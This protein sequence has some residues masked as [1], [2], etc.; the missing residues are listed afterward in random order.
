M[1]C[2]EYFFEGRRI[3]FTIFPSKFGV[4]K[5]RKR[6]HL[7]L[8]LCCTTMLPRLLALWLAACCGITLVSCEIINFSKHVLY[9]GMRS[10]N[11]SFSLRFALVFSLFPLYTLIFILLFYYF[12]LLVFSCLNI[13]HC[14][15]RHITIHIGIHTHV[16]SLTLTQSLL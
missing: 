13:F 3:Q 1:V 7:I 11:D 6:F 2:S 9:P 16:N 14:L 10:F 4:K 15:F 8:T 5:A 12:A